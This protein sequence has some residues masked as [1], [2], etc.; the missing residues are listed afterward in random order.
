MTTSTNTSNQSSTS[1]RTAKDAGPAARPASPGRGGSRAGRWAGR[2]GAI[3]RIA[4][5]LFFVSSGL[6]KL[7]APAVWI[8]DFTRWNV[9]LPELAVYGVG[10]LEVVG[11]LALALGV[12][13]RPVAA[14]LA[15]NM[16]GA[17]LLAGL[18]DG[19]QHL[20]LPP[21]LGAVTALVTL[22][23]GGAWQLRPGSRRRPRR[24]RR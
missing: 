18:V 6:P 5:G 4:V 12:A 21:V 22:R 13:T 14:L 16:G 10:A 3:A 2:I 20:V 9:P 1:S 17:V 8:T 23:G 19:G 24:G 7:T 15:A 11:G